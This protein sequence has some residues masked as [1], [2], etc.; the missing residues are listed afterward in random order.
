MWSRWLNEQLN[1]CT[2]QTHRQWQ[3]VHSIYSNYSCGSIEYISFLIFHN[4]TIWR[5]HLSFHMYIY[6]FRTP[7]VTLYHNQNV[8]RIHYSLINDI[9]FMS[10]HIRNVFNVIILFSFSS[11]SFILVNA[12]HCSAF[13]HF[14]CQTNRSQFS[15]LVWIGQIDFPYSVHVSMRTLWRRVNIPTARWQ[16]V[17][18]CCST[19]RHIVCMWERVTYLRWLANLKSFLTVCH[20]QARAGS[21]I[22]LYIYIYIYMYHIQMQNICVYI[23]AYISM[24]IYLRG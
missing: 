21:F 2:Q 22:S 20:N 7:N 8:L 24:R 14:F 18:R 17:F 9:K 23:Y 15:S 12:C 10:A 6:H 19:V 5:M 13:Q 4:I 11:M 1:Y 16:H 3:R